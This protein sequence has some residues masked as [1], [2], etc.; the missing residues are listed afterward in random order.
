MNQ[1]PTIL[2]S[3]HKHY[4]QAT[5]PLRTTPL[6]RHLN[7][8][9]SAQLRRRIRMTLAFPFATNEAHEW[10]DCTGA[11]SIRCCVRPNTLYLVPAGR[12]ATP[13]AAV[14][15][16]SDI[17]VSGRFCIIP[18]CTLPLVERLEMG[19]ELRPLVCLGCS[20]RGSRYFIIHSVRF[21]LP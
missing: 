8:G 21:S 9:R 2:H 7:T 17:N 6:Y 15:E 1:R 16:S 19:L 13:G 20:S 10:S 11:H 18:M 4:R 14:R 5:Q 12:A 3:Y